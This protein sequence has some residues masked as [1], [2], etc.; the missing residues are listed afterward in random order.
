VGSAA[1]PFI[2]ASA[3]LEV[4]YFALLATVYARADYS[5]AYPVAWGAAPVL[6]LAVSV[7]ALGAH[8]GALAAVGVLVVTVGVLMV[9][10]IGA[11]AAS[12]AA[13][14]LALGVGSCIAAYTLVDDRGVRH[15]GALPYFEVVLA[16][17]ALP[18]AA[19][20]G[21]RAV[22]GALDARAVVAGAG[23]A[24]AYTL[25]LLALELAEAAPVAAL[26]QVSVVLAAG[27]AALAG[28]ERVPARRVVGAVLVVAGAAAITLG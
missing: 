20:V 17:M 3:V 12:R 19:A 21:P 7:T 2:A 11:A 18:Y 8:V 6:V 13:T 15:A 16:L 25:V 4:T 5:F 28:R 27:G 23:M 24:G 22:W 10:G 1:L 14:L 26:R 9:R